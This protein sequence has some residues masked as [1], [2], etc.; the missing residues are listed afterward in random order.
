MKNA[1]DKDINLFLPKKYNFLLLGGNFLFSKRF[2]EIAKRQYDIKRIDYQYVNTEE[3]F[4][5][6]ESLG[7]DIQIESL[8]KIDTMISLY[9]SNVLILTSEILLFLN[10]AKYVEFLEF[11][12]SLKK[13]NIKIVFVNIENPLHIYKKSDHKLELSNMSSKCWYKNRIS[14]TLELMDSSKDLIY[15]CSS[16][17]TYLN[18]NIQLN[19]VNLIKSNDD[20]LIC[21]NEQES[22]IN[23]SI[24]DDIVNDLIYNLTNTGIIKYNNNE[25]QFI[26]LKDLNKNY[27]QN[28]IFSYVLNQ[29]NC[30][31]NLIYR[32]KPSEFQNQKSVANWRY[33]LGRS[34]AEN[35][36]DSIKN[37]LDIIVP[38]PETGKYYAQGIAD[39]MKKPYVEAFFK[40]TD[41]GR[42]F[43]IANSD[44]RNEFLKCKLDVIDDLIENKVVGIV[45]EAI[46]TGQT[47]KVVKK[48]LDTTSVKKI[49][50]LIASPVCKN[51]CTFNM[52]PDRDLLSINK[53]TSEIINFFDVEGIIFQDLDKYRKIVCS[54]GLNCSC[55]FD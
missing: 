37:E 18:S 3:Y 5:C 51:K 24:A 12:K 21:E 48:L 22:S 4:D 2:Y 8:K 9:D 36:P 49:Y 28:S 34:L 25:S 13:L 29:S 55:C 19:I 26:K 40:K 23:L 33:D 31:L 45:D 27:F 46:F 11:F 47:L 10:E 30:S 39:F 16:Y 52:M 7:V 43:D 53:S 38:I 41:I 17:L 6:I 44:K 42:S 32:K 20:Y 14:Q 35:I 54:S 1:I 50:F 15:E